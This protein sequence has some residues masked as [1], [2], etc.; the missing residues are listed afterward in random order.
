MSSLWHL[1]LSSFM[2]VKRLIVK[3]QGEEYEIC[4]E[5]KAPPNFPEDSDSKYYTALPI[6]NLE[7]V[8]KRIRGYTRYVIGAFQEFSEAEVEEVTLRFGLKIG[9]SNGIPFLSE[10]AEKGNFEIEVKCKFSGRN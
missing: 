9:D 10:G 1:D 7:E 4:V 8:H 2:S 6:V 3:D 5:S